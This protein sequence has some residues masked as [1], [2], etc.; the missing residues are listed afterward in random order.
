MVFPCF[1]FKTCGSNHVFG[2]I[3]MLFFLDRLYSNCLHP[4]NWR[5]WSSKWPTFVFTNLLPTYH[6][7]EWRHIFV[8]PPAPLELNLFQPRSKAYVDYKMT[9]TKNWMECKDYI[10][11]VWAAFTVPVVK[12]VNNEGW[13]QFFYIRRFNQLPFL[14]V[15]RLIS[16]HKNLNISPWWR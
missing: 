10:K 16:L 8:Q 14:G 9:F 13:T 15:I 4:R 1:F 3:H 12:L 6:C 5:V 11:G 2:Q 7:G